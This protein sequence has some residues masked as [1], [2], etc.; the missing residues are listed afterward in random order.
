MELKIYII[1]EKS[2]NNIQAKET[3]LFFL[4]SELLLSRQKIIF[5]SMIR[6]HII[7]YWEFLIIV[8]SLSLEDLSI[9]IQNP[10]F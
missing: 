5:D 2:S 4:Q 6:D 9:A 8:S 3:F 1:F 7:L 10:I